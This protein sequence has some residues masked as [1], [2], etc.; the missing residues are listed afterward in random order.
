[1]AIEISTDP[2]TGERT[3]TFS[4]PDTLQEAD[5]YISVVGSF[6]DWMPGIHVL[7]AGDDGQLAVSVPLTS[8]DDLH[9]RYL[10]TGGV[11]FDDPQADEQTLHGSVARVAASTMSSPA[12]ESTEDDLPADSAAASPKK[13]ASQ[14]KK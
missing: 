1:M 13:S 3:A 14:T 11:W 12:T 4:L 7:A 6:N 5:T 9:F 8:D 2:A 10:Q